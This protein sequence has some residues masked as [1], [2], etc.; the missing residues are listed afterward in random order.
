MKR[1][2]LALI[3]TWTTTGSFQEQQTQQ[4]WNGRLSDSMCG[5]SHQMKAAGKLSERECVFECIKALGKYVFVDEKQQVIPILNQDFGGFPLY[6]GRT[7]KI[8]GSLKDGGILA[9][10]IERLESPAK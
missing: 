1:A 2:L 4:V 10:K 5:A 6:A 7:V 9:T 3:I 8:T